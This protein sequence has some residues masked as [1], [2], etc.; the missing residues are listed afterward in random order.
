[1]K[2][3]AMSFAAVAA[4][5]A[6]AP[7]AAQAAPWQSINQRQANLDQRIDQ[8]VRSGALTRPEAQRLRSELASLDR[9]EARYRAS[10]GLDAR[11][12]ADLDRR[13]DQLAAQVRMEKHDAQRRY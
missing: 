8:G 9:L 3:V 1:M 2:R 12:R 13:F 10:H 6:I 5:L 4:V 7:A 11:E